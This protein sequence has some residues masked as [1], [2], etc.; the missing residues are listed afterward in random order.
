MRR[1]CLAGT[2][3]AAYDG[4]QCWQRVVG[5]APAPNDPPANVADR[6]SDEIDYLQLVYRDRY[7]T[8]LLAITHARSIA[9]LFGHCDTEQDFQRRVAVLADLLAQLNPYAPFGDSPPLDERG[10][11]LRPLL[12]LQRLME[13]DYPEAIEAVRA[14]A[15]IPRIRQSFPVHSRTADVVSDMRAFGVEYPASDWHLAWL[16]VLTAF[17]QSLQS[18][19][20]A[21]QAGPPSETN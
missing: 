8:K 17:W 15:R 7:G 2:A 5:G 19:R 9:E 11:R 20:R 13:R 18:L 6:A 12:T 10:D 16:R 4:L 21:I 1:D 14:L 3:A